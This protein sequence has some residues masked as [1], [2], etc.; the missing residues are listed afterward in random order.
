M[1]A[2]QAG[3]AAGLYK[4]KATTM[5]DGHID[6]RMA[7][8]NAASQE[9]AEEELQKQK[10]GS[11]PHPVLCAN[12]LV[13]AGT[14]QGCESTETNGHGGSGVAHIPGFLV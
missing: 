5:Q 6:R 4:H 1:C 14:L 13:H 11:S 3:A 8:R 9:E 2:T 10:V 7:F 12:R